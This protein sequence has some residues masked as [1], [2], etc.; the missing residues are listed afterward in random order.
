MTRKKIK[1]EDAD[2]LLFDVDR[3][4]C[5]CTLPGKAVQIHHIDGNHQNNELTNLIVLCLECHDEVTRGPS[6]GR[7]ISKGYL[8]LKK[9]FWTE[10]VSEFRSSTLSIKLEPSAVNNICL[11]SSEYELKGEEEVKEALYSYLTFFRA[12]RAKSQIFLDVGTTAS[13]N[14]AMNVMMDDAIVALASLADYFPPGHFGASPK[15]YFERWARDLSGLHFNISQRGDYGTMIGYVTASKTLTSLEAFFL[16]MSETLAFDY[17][18]YQDWSETVTRI[19]NS[20]F[21]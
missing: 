4:C 16:E 9:Q 8:L 19:F 2:Q 13:N 15:Q 14:M 10:K 12:S 3:T 18:W 5:L 11:T 7:G 21:E 20:D 6:L 17:D 1:E